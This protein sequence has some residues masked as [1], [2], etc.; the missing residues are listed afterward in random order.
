MNKNLY[1]ILI[2]LNISIKL[3]SQQP[4]S[5]LVNSY[6]E[7]LDL[8]KKSHLN[9]EGISL[10][11]VL[12]SA[13]VEAIQ[14]DEKNPGT[15]YVA[16][17][18]GNLWKTI[19]NGISWKPIFNDVPSLGIGD[20]A[21]SPSNPDVIYL[22]TGES[23]KK[24]RNFTMPGTG[25]YK[26]VDAGETWMHIGLNDS[27]HI[28]EISIHPKN[29]DIVYV[30]VLGHFWTSNE[31]RGVY[32]TINGGKSWEKVLYID[33]KTGSIDIVVSPS[34]P[35]IVYASMWEN[36]PSIS[37]KN[38]SVYKS[39]DSGTNWK[40]IN[41]GL[42]YGNKT[43]RI[44]L[45]VSYS[46]SSK[47]YALVDNLA[48]ERNNAAEVY[49][50]IDG[51]E[52]WKKTHEEN[53]LI[54][55][56]IGWYFADIYVS[57]INDDEVYALGVRTAKSSNGGKNFKNIK[58]DVKRLNPSAAKGL[59]LDNCEL[60]INPLN[61]NHIALGNDG[62]LFISYDKG[63][64]WLHYNNIP[65]G[66]FYD[67]E[68]DNQNPYN[69]YG[70]TQD[71]ATV[72][73]PAVEWNNLFTD[74]WKY[75]W[76]DA[77]DGGDG[78]ITQVDPSDP[79][80]VYFSMQNGAIRRKDMIK[81]YSLSIKPKLPDN[82]NDNLNYNFITPYFISNH[83]HKT[84]YHAG[85]YVF[86]SENRGDTWKLISNNLSKSEFKNKISFSAG[87]IA[88][89]P[90]EKGVIYY[91]S[92]RGSFWVTK[93]DG[94]SW[95]EESNNIE[96]NYIRSISPSKY[97]N[98][99]VYMSMTGINYDDLSNYIYLSENYGKKWEKISSNLPNEPV[100]IV[101][102]DNKY[103]NIIYAGMYRGVYISLDR[104]LNWMI[105][106]NNLPIASVSDIEIHNES[107]DMIVSTHGR[108]IY[109][110]NLNPIH[111]YFLNKN[112]LKT[113]KLLNIENGFLPKF[114]DTHK[115]AII[116][117][118]EKLPI[119]FYLNEDKDFNLKIVH[120]NKTIWELNSNGNYG[121]NQYRWD[122]IIKRVNNQ[123]PYF[124]HFNEYILP[125]EYKMILK[126]K[127]STSENIFNIY[128]K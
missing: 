106:G 63:K 41:N 74:K 80:T 13:R 21:L 10:G 51:G 16:F 72:Y 15:M 43:G 22:G 102:E 118:Y 120:N 94:E 86:K 7:H 105:L 20:I 66:E 29:P 114:N 76:I 125:G 69:I 37:G 40:K 26:S 33:E 6:K 54:F 89:S 67:I 107:N 8:K 27:W 49:V 82:I 58:G 111:N 116:D 115:E 4:Y 31:N 113:D 108:G 1:I 52:I 55:P 53:L 68:I 2:F 42:P 47:I 124:I 88:E 75:L 12:N 93:N 9:L 46:N 101:I 92:D 95:K 11:P 97:K 77:W 56:G 64:S 121:I 109:K 104:G 99:R 65:V 110:I 32:R 14:I 39:I 98:S 85:N 91:G 28:G 81:D 23:L 24:A 127:D 100:N 59:H 3:F 73:G 45:A 71:D 126:T 17:G 61:D 5:P 30:S 35:N 87:A 112:Y 122:L 123:N 44:G 90:I 79:N 57:P 96:N 83:N 84:L 128:E 117:T 60:W 38:S 103:E 18:S 62:G 19:N 36:F 119:T 25:I 34:E 48:N 70:G 78:C 50:S